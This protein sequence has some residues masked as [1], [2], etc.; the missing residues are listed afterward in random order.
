MFTNVDFTP[1]PDAKQLL[2]T[3]KSY[4]KEGNIKGAAVSLRATLQQDPDDAEARKLLGDLYLTLGNGQAAEKELGR[5]VES[6]MEPNLVSVGMARARIIQARYQEVINDAADLAG[7]DAASSAELLALHGHA[8]FGLHQYKSA[9]EHY[10]RS[11]ALESGNVEAL[12]G[13]AYLA[14]RRNQVEQARSLLNSATQLHPS[15][16]M[17]WS[18]LGDLEAQLGQKSAAESAYSRAI[19]VADANRDFLKRAMVRIDLERFTAAKS[20]IE[21]LRR[22]GAEELG[23]TI[24]EGRVRLGM[25]DFSGALQS[26]RNVLSKEPSDAAGLLLA[27][28]A[29]YQLGEL[30]QAATYLRDHLSESPGSPEGSMVLASLL[31]RSGKKDA[32]LEVVRAARRLDSDNARLVEFEALINVHA[33]R[34]G[35]AI[36]VLERIALDNPQ[37]PGAF[38]NLGISLGLIGK[39][40]E[41]Q[42]ALG[43][44]AKLAPDAQAPRVLSFN[45][46]LQDRKFSAALQEAKAISEQWP[47]RPEGPTLAAIAHIAQ[48]N[49][50]L[51][52]TLLVKA[53]ELKQGFPFASRVLARVQLRKGQLDEA[54]AVLQTAEKTQPYLANSL[55]LAELESRTGRIDESIAVL[56]NAMQRSPQSLVVRLN[57]AEQYQR[58]G[59]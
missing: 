18:L 26:F 38:L 20:D 1:A 32:A 44:A 33:G 9:E 48:G 28:V 47:D 29:A 36:G 4:L 42:A 6:G 49:D 35:A 23:L 17:P 24:A 7:L 10:T 25:K 43:T 15:E 13:A 19:T 12:I 22:R 16:G 5:A 58:L 39:S 14:A 54:R 55:M 8:Y 27:G 31:L 51:A 41:A 30:D 46:A 34:A 21:Q 37:E 40:T 56:R 45:Q 50:E 57:L 59:K 53:L 52:E 11:Q 3:A 2:A